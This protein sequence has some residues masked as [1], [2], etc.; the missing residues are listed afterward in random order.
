MLVGDDDRRV[1]VAADRD[2]VERQAVVVQ[3]VLEAP[4]P[5]GLVED[6]PDGP[7]AD[8][9]VDEQPVE[10]GFVADAFGPRPGVEQVVD[11]GGHEASLVS[12]CPP[13][14]D[15]AAALA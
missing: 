14:S 1:A 11:V 15:V 5:A 13:G 10:R 8:E 4:E 2:L 9:V 3:A 7:D 12:W 6:E